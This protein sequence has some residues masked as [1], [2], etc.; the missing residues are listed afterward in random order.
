MLQDRQ[1]W[2]NP[3]PSEVTEKPHSCYACSWASQWPRYRQPGGDVPPW[4]GP[5]KSSFSFS[6]ITG[7][8]STTRQVQATDLAPKKRCHLRQG[9]TT[10]RARARKRPMFQWLT[11]LVLPLQWEHLRQYDSG[12]NRNPCCL[13][14]CLKNPF[15]TECPTSSISK[16]GRTPGPCTSWHNS[17]GHN[18]CTS[19]GLAAK[20]LL[21]PW[22]PEKFG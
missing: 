20:G 16:G 14:L 18:L 9:K 2:C 7:G 15:R 12:S 10:P 6:E 22:N 13:Q 21:V 5:G 19:P 11:V 1:P 8:C 4:Q 3:H 17:A